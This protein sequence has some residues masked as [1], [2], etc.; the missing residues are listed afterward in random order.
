MYPPNQQVHYEYSTSAQDAYF[1]RER[2]NHSFDVVERTIALLGS[3][4]TAML[5]LRF[6][7]ALLDANQANGIVSFVNGVTAPFVTPFVGI[8]NYDHA[9]VGNVSFQGYTL[10]AMLAY[11]LLTAGITRLASISRY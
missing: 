6:A 1:R 3:S 9:S 5:G 10:V 7:F 2:F 11:S 8:F 4:L